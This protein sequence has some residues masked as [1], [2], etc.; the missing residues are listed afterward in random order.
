MFFQYLALM[1][2]EQERAVRAGYHDPFHEHREERNS[3]VI[4]NRGNGSRKGINVF[5]FPR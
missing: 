3:E 5:P 1:G 2:L 4:S